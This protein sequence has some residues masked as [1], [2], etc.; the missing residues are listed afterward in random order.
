[1]GKK[2]C[3]SSIIV[4]GEMKL[5]AIRYFVLYAEV[6]QNAV[7]HGTGLKGNVEQ[8]A[9]IASGSKMCRFEIQVRDEKIKEK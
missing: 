1:M 5:A 7:S 9:S 4:P 2:K 8:K 6:L 3:S